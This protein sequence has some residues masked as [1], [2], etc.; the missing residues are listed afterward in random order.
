MSCGFKCNHG[1]LQPL[2]KALEV[3]L[4]YHAGLLIVSSKFGKLLELGRVFV[5]FPSFHSELKQFLFS[6]FSVHD[7]LEILGKVCSR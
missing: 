3:L 5:Q 7:I 1:F 2:R 4:A 6:L